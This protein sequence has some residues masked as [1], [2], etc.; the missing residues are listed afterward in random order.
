ME[1]TLWNRNVKARG[2]ILSHILSVDS[3]RI[4]RLTGIETD[5]S[6]LANV[7]ISRKLMREE[8]KIIEQD[9][10]REGSLQLIIYGQP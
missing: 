8:H 4:T 10:L 3:V 5:C 7:F 9:S 6:K 2:H 1:G